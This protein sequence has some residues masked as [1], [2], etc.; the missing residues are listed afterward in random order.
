MNLFDM[1]VEVSDLVE[2]LRAAV[3]CAGVELFW[4]LGPGSVSMD[5]LNVAPEIPSF[6]VL[7]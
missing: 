2:G 7:F 5:L 6:R 3:K 4:F 1:A